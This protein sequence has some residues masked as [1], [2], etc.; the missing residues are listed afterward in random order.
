M[1]Y[2]PPLSRWSSGWRY[3]GSVAISLLAWS[4]YLTFQWHEQRTLFWA[5]VAIGVVAYLVVHQRRRHPLTVALALNALAAF[6]GAAAGPATLAT[7]S[8]ATRRQL[9]E[10]VPVTVFAL[11][12]AQ[13]YATVQPSSNRDPYWV[14]LTVNTIFIAATLAW[15]LFIGSRRELLWTL[16]DRAQRAEQQRDLRLGKARS[17]ERARIAREMH[18]VLAHRISQVSMQS[19]ALAFREDLSA[20]QMRGTAG[21]IQQQANLALLDLRAVLGVL[22]DPESGSLLDRPQPTY[23]DVET[24]IDEARES[25]MHVEHRVELTDENVPEAAGRTAY[26]IVQEGLT[27]ARKH[28]AGALVR[29]SITGGP[30]TG[31]EIEILNPLG[32]TTPPETPGAGLGLVGLAERAELSGGW[33]DHRREGNAFVLAGWIPWN[34]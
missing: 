2:Q 14:D 28:A 20:A 29:L 11:G 13:L 8:V 4:P 9:R 30:D 15:G 10:L 27:N 32:F 23:K 22:R 6:S 7:V 33:I 12:G 21:D 24:L 3:A 34:T 19:G 17:D 1:L 16:R 26:R 18:D 25:G 5:D 31:L